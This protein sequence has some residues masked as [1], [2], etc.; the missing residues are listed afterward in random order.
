VP[1]RYTRKARS[2]GSSGVAGKGVMV[3]PLTG[4]EIRAGSATEAEAVRPVSHKNSG[5]IRRGSIHY[6]GSVPGKWIVA[7]AWKR[8]DWRPG[9]AWG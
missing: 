8:Q 4:V 6:L 7:T 3:K 5:N 1:S 9:Q 2:F